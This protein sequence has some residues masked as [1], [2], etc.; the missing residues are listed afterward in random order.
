MPGIKLK[1]KT[2]VAADA[3]ST[4]TPTNLKQIADVQASKIAKMNDKEL[5]NDIVNK[6][7]SGKLD[8]KAQDVDSLATRNIKKR[9]GYKEGTKGIKMKTK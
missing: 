8:R 5:F 4:K 9:G 3:T 7:V 1:P 6:E 2:V